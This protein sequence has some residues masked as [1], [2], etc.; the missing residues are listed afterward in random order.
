MQKPV[1]LVAVVAL[2]SLL[3]TPALVA[4]QSISSNQIIDFL[5][6]K[7]FKFQ[8]NWLYTP[9][10]LVLNVIIPT[11]AI[12]AIFLGMMRTLQIFRGMGNME[13]MIAILVAL[14]ALFTGGIGYVSGLLA[15]LGNFSV[16]I[17]FVLMIIG[18][19]LYSVG[20]VRKSTNFYKEVLTAEQAVERHYVK[21]IT[22]IEKK[23][24]KLM[25]DLKHLDRGSAQEI[26]TRQKITNLEEKITEIKNKVKRAQEKVTT[27]PA[28]V[29]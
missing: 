20:F 8:I 28:G 3:L 12:Y 5:W 27:M 10:L 24:R 18:M 22:D 17:F 26:E 16:I 23:Q 4:A 19:I 14:S 2:F 9:N 7:T 1:L 11:L 6:V 29:G 15:G 25:S 13:H 21:Q